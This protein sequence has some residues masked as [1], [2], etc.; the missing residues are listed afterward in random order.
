[1]LLLAAITAP[2]ALS[3][4]ADTPKVVASHYDVTLD[5]QPDGS[6]DVV[7]RITLASGDAPMSW[8]ERRVPERRTDGLTNIVALLDGQA[9]GARVRQRRG[10]DARWEFPPT[11]N[12]T[13]VIELRYRAVHVLARELAGWRVRWN[14]LPAEHSYPIQQARVTMRAPKAAL[15]VALSAEGGEMQPATSWADGLVVTRAATGKRD[16]I[17]IDVTFSAETVRPNEP[18]WAVA[19]EQA[20]KLAPAFIAGAL[21]LLVVGAGTLVMVRISTARDPVTAAGAQDLGEATAEAPAV[22]AALI[23]CGRSNWLTVQAAFFRLVRDGALVIARVEGRRHHFTVTHGR[24][25]PLAGHEQWIIDRVGSAPDADLSRVSRWLLRRQAEFDANVIGELRDRGWMDDSRAS[26]SAAL[27]TSGVVLTAVGLLSA[28]VLALWLVPT[29]GPA[30]LLIPAA[31]LVDAAAFVIGA[32]QLSLLSIEG[33][34]VRARWQRRLTELRQVERSGGESLD[35]FQRW[36][37][38]MVGTGEARRWL[39]AFDAALRASGAGIPWLREM[40]SMD[41]AGAMIAMVA[42]ASGATHAGGAA[43]VAGAGGGSSAAG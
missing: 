24:P 32:H 16:G 35:V 42:G 27:T 11:S 43:G 20:R 12:G 39:K 9:G 36:L 26:T 5:L 19:E 22:A 1:M 13:R 3:A 23:N 21:A 17:A 15:A 38:L 10:I 8:F 31:L 34:R 6:L 37:P 29:L 14:A 30:L 7:E 18:A 28:L 40:G 25:T 4:R 2:V 33:E 41:D